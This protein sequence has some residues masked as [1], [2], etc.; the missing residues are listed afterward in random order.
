M[1]LEREKWEY[2]AATPSIFVRFSIAVPSLSPI[3]LHY[4]ERSYSLQGSFL[5]SVGEKNE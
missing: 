5:L 4:T 1:K 3:V 2:S